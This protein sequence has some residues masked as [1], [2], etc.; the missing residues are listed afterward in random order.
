MFL[1]RSAQRG[2]HA[3]G[4]PAQAFV[5]TEEGHTHDDADDHVERHRPAGLLEVRLMLIELCDV[6]FA[7]QRLAALGVA[8]DAQADGV[9]ERQADDR[10]Y[11]A[12]ADETFPDAHGAPSSEVAPKV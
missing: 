12:S 3:L 7:G 1:P 11:E 4:A 2:D 6:G 9:P 8:I 10:D 5:H